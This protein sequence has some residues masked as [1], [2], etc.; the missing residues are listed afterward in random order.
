M[1]PNWVFRLRVRM[2]T[3]IRPTEVPATI[4][5]LGFPPIEVSV[6]PR[7][8]KPCAL[9][10]KQNC[11]PSPQPRTGGERFIFEA[12][13]FPTEDEAWGAGVRF[14]DALL[15]SGALGYLGIDLG[16]SKATQSFHQMIH[17]G[18]RKDTGRELR[19]EHFGLMVFQKDTVLIAGF[20]AEGHTLTSAQSVAATLSKWTDVRS[21]LTARQRVCAS[22]LNDSFYVGHADAQFILRISAVEAL[23]DQRDVG[24]EYSQT[25]DALIAHLESMGADV[26]SRE[27]ARRVLQR[28]RKESL[29]QAYLRKIRQL[30]GNEIAE[31]FDDLYSLRSKYVHEGV[32]RGEFAVV[33]GRALEI[34]K[35]LLECELISAKPNASAA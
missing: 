4:S 22:L 28:S 26:T 14:S 6:E 21:A 35:Q 2:T 11:P 30:L 3:P 9:D 31:E 24:E 12:H 25:I 7:P 1:T 18:V 13:N 5:V 16:K 10:A 15:I 32:G 8:R 33:A 34:A 29:R 23:C 19:A 20:N 17:D 27:S